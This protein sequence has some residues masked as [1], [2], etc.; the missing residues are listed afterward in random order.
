MPANKTTQQTQH[1]P[2]PWRVYRQPSKTWQGMYSLHVLASDQT[3]A[4]MAAAIVHVAGTNPDDEANARLIAAAPEMLE[5]LAT[6]LGCAETDSMDDK[7]NVWRSAI[8][9]AR[10]T[11]A[12]ATG[13]A[14]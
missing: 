1:T 14:Q 6:L 3:P 9:D 2:G 12:K 5:A 7:S 8:I 11:I 10:A 4:E 13:G